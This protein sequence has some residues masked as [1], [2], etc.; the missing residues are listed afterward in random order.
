MENKESVPATEKIKEV[1]QMLGESACEEMQKEEPYKDLFSKSDTLE[2]LL[3][4]TKHNMMKYILYA[5]NILE[6]KFEQKC[7]DEA[8]YILLGLPLFV[9]QL[10]KRIEEKE[11]FSCC[12]DKTFYILSEVLTKIMNKKE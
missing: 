11:G 3:R 6:K 2:S 7:N 4:E 1:I 9:E 5:S 10:G 8:F 12:V